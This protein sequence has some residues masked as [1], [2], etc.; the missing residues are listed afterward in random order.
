MHPRKIKSFYVH[1]L[2][3]LNA[4]FYVK[5]IDDVYVNIVALEAMFSL[6]L[7]NLMFILDAWN[8][9]KSFLNHLIFLSSIF[10]ILVMQNIQLLLGV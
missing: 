4:E 10:L 3:I 5:V 2:E 8:L 1:S 7:L 9:V 6:Q